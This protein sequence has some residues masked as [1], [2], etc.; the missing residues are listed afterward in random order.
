MKILLYLLFLNSFFS[1]S[2]KTYLEKSKEYFESAE[3][4][5]DS[6]DYSGAI[7]DYTKAIETMQWW[8]IYFNRDTCKYASGDL[9]GACKDVRKAQ[10][11]G[12]D[13]SE[14]IK[15]TCK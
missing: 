5:H 14:I 13:S 6:I 11:L 3:L 2:K 1:I 12:I 10:K 4:K 15:L 9:D 8:C 7:E